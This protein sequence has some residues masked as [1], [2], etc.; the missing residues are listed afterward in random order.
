M[1][2]T[3]TDGSHTIYVP[4]I[5]E[6]YHSSNGAMQ[7][8]MHI[9][10][11]T[12]LHTHTK[13][14]L[15]VFEVGFGTGLNALLTLLDARQRG[16]SVNYIAVELYPVEVELAQELNYPT[17]VNELY[18]CTQDDFMNLHRAPWNVPQQITPHFSLTKIQGDF[19]TISLGENAFDVVYFDAFSPEKQGEMWTEQNMQRIYNA[20]QPHAVLSTYCAK[21]VVR[22]SLQS[23]GFTVE[24]LPGPP[25]KREILRATKNE[26]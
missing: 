21:G 23:V 12:A 16:V 2:L 14:E 10:I 13:P 4:S 11:K 9:F 1:L 7:E 8:S 18:A 22:R 17:V 19:N 25:G 20:C 3:T 24:R 26:R 15:T 6:C 5:D